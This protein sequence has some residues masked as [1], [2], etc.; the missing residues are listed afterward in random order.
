MKPHLKGYIIG[1]LCPGRTCLLMGKRAITA[2]RC[3]R[4]GVEM[5]RKRHP[6]HPKKR[7]ARTVKD[8]AELLS[9]LR[10]LRA[11][12]EKAEAGRR[13][14]GLPPLLS[15]FDSEIVDP[16]PRPRLLC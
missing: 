16:L 1:R 11:K 6:R 7:A 13:L 4:K 3:K 10:Q 15:E 8:L 9:E 2:E 5:E 14:H 12:V